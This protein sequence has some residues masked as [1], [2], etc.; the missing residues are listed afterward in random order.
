MLYRI[1]K[2]YYFNVK[3][4]QSYKPL[5]GLQISKNVKKIPQ[6]LGAFVV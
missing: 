5:I 3:C 1:I 2:L 6:F 4:V